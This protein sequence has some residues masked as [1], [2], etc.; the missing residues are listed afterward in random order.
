MI[1]R[2]AFYREAALT[3]VAIVAVLVVVLVLFGMTAILGRAVKGDIAEKVVLQMF[4]WQTLRRLDLLLPLGLYL[5]V[6]MTFS[7]WYRDSEMTVLHACGV[8][9]L[10]LLRPVLIFTAAV[11]LLTAAA[12]FYLT[13]LANRAIETLKIEGNSRPDI[14]GIVPGTFS[15]GSLGRVVYAEESL[16]EGRLNQ[17][18]VSTPSGPQP[19][20]ILS[21]L[22]HSIVDPKT[23]SR[24]IALSNGWAYEGKPGDPNYRI[25]HFDTYLVRIDSKPLIVPP[26]TVEGLPTMKLFA[27]DQREAK[28]EWH[29]RLSKPILALVLAAFA[30]VMS[31]TDARRGR[32]ANLFAAILV[33]FIYS[34]LLGAGQTLLRQGRVS[35]AWGLWWVHGLM[36]LVVAYWLYRRS[37]NRPL[38]PLLLR[39]KTA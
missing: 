15:E 2:R 39:R 8:S 29:W 10:Q 6:L 17:V 25:V 23:G 18:F 31:Y 12:A 13:P 36:I 1:I 9:L 16:A 7:R 3:T 35:P 20:V 22:G 4:G 28:A 38:L 30:L 21:R 33:Y 24:Y 14:T 5:G 34:N 27:L 37:Y 26:D 19:R 32:L 11:A